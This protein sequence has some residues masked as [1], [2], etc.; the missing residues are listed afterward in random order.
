MRRGIRDDRRGVRRGMATVELA[1][2]MPLLTLMLFG[3][4]EVSR[5]VAVKQSIA[6]AAREGARQASTG[7]LTNSEVEA[8]VTRYLQNIG[9]PTAHVQITVSNLTQAGVDVKQAAQLDRVK[10]GVSIPFG[11]VRLLSSSFAINPDTRVGSEA[12]WFCMKDKPYPDPD[13][14]PI[15]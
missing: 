1:I 12:T 13:D 15:E 11:D 3:L 8:V 5:L 6:N 14:P 10:V 4:W 2:L 7:R 9:L